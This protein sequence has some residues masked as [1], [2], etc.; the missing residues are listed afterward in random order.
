MALRLGVPQPHDAHRAA[1]RLCAWRR[2]RLRLPA[3]ASDLAL[4]RAFPRDHLARRGRRPFRDRRHR[5][6]VGRHRA[7]R[8]RGRSAATESSGLRPRRGCLLR[9][10]RALRRERREVLVLRPRLWI[11]GIHRER[12]RLRHA[13]YDAPSRVRCGRRCA[14]TCASRPSERAPPSSPTFSSSGS[15]QKLRS[16]S[17]RRF[18]TRASSSRH[19]SP[20]GSAKA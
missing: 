12:L 19:S 18:A 9:G 14:R 5:A 6:R 17:A 7:L 4:A 13:A 1:A 15:G 3:G 16:R 10:L 2:L 20:R 11:H 8:L